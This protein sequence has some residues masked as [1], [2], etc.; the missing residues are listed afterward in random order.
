MNE[1]IYTEVIPECPNIDVYL[2]E[3][4]INNIRSLLNEVY[5]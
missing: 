5:K 3:N 4:V 2:Q 1:I